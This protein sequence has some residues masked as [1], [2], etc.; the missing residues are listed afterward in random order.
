[1]IQ[2]P[3]P[4]THAW[5]Q[6]N[7]SD[8]FGNTFYTKNV[9]FDDMG[10]LKLSG[11]P[12]AV[13]NEVLNANFNN[14]A[15]II[16]SEDHGY[17]TVTWDQLFNV[18]NEPLYTTPVQTTGFGTV[19]S[20][21]AQSDTA[22]FGGNLVV[23]QDTDVDYYDQVGNTWIDTNISLTG[24]SQSQHPVVNFLSYNQLAI[25]N[26]NTVRLYATPITATPVL[27][28]TL[29]LPNDFFI[30]SMCYFNQNLY[31]GTSNRYGEKAALYVWNGQ[32]TAAQGVFQVDSNIIFDVCVF[33]ES[34]IIFAGNGR[35][36]QFNG[37]G[38][39]PLPNGEFPLFF[40]NL[41]LTDETNISIYRGCLKSN[42]NLLYIS[43]SDIQNTRRIILNQPSGIWCYDPKVGL[44]NRYSLSNSIV[45]SQSI[46]TG[47]VNTSTNQIIVTTAPVTGTEVYYRTLGGTA[48]GGIL[49]QTKYFVINIDSTHIQLATTLANAIAGTPI[50]LTG[51]GNNSQRLT[52]FPK[53]DYGQFYN[54]RQIGLLA[55]NLSQTYPEYGTDIIWNGE[56]GTR[57]SPDVGDAHLGSISMGV[58]SRGYWVSPKV[59]SSNVTDIVN[60][61]NIKYA[62][63]NELDKIIVKYRRI[64]DNRNTI[65]LSIS[66]NWQ[67]TWTSSSTFTTTYSAFATASVENEIE[68]LSGAAGGLLAHITAISEASG[69]YTVTIDESFGDYVTGDISQAVFRNW[70]KIMTITD[71]NT[72]GFKSAQI[73][74]TGTFIQIKIEL[75]GIG[76]KIEA[77]QL[78]NTTFKPSKR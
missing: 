22:W 71:S 74:G 28:T 50:D 51:T 70:I 10:Y 4:D 45:Y 68:V 65:D 18:D 59:F 58:E 61:V 53:T 47:N 30:T 64:D 27:V 23:T 13:I 1:M 52:F 32:G 35:L 55:I 5:S 26:V 9:M 34:V 6:P 67:I 14:S 25:A 46:G 19:P 43:F 69:T 33:Q 39:S 7:N 36:L 38:F 16:K 57:T 8:L 72:E 40:A 63:L 24:T 73:G 78:D 12:K 56:L 44:Y 37:S 29:I 15:A 66:T 60:Q 76:T 20:G 3:S 11:A 48:I 49:N 17:L 77:I 41:H 54:N 21:D 31:I 2:I 75:R 62:P 42:G